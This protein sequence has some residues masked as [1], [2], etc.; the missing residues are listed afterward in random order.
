MA[1]LADAL[2]LGSSGQPWGFKSPL[3]HHARVGGG[4]GVILRC[5]RIHSWLSG[6]YNLKR[7]GILMKFDVEELGKTK[8]RLKI[9]IPPEDIAAALDKAYGELNK[10]V[11]VDGF[12]PGKAPRAILEKRYGQTVESEVMERIVPDSYVKAVH[13]AG[14]FPVSDP[15]IAETGLKIRPGEPL[16]FTAEVEVRPEF[17]LSEYKGIPVADEPVEVGDQELAD[18][19]EELRRMHATLEPVDEERPARAGDH[20][21]IDFEGFLDG[22]AIEGGKS[23]NYTLLLGSDTLVPGFEEQVAGMSKGESREIQ[24][25]FPDGYRDK[26]LAGRDVVFKV[27]LKA[28]QKNVLPELDGEFAKDLGIGEGLEELKERLKADL[29]AHKRQKT[30]ARQKQEIMK[31]LLEKNLFDLPPSLVEKEVRHMV[32]RRH[33]EM[34]ASSQT[35]SE[36]GFDLK[37]FK[38]QAGPAAETRVRTSL[39]LTAIAEAE[40]VTVSDAEVER[41]MRAMSAETGYS[42]DEIKRLYQKKEGGLDGIRA[43]L[44]EEK[45]M[46]LLLKEAKKS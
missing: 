33:Q 2:D 37:A 44:G 1:E 9:E 10:G 19:L 43:V 38:E 8:K 45:V 6:S 28:V 17:T 42:M 5:S 7:S 27:K 41:Y 11:K 3:S 39:I 23:E 36:A 13:E 4:N 12:R 24:V 21:L 34:L 14:I 46:E 31:T 26:G 20:V 35:P 16:S 29:L 32:L 40:G 18:A 25:R 30:G 22:T 15:A